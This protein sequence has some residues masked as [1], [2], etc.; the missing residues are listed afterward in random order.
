MTRADWYTQHC[1]GGWRKARKD[2]RC[3]KRDQ[4]GLR[5]HGIILAGS[6]YFGTNA[7]NPHSKNPHARLRLCGAC[8]CEA[9]K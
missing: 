2:N 1:G 7:A 8:A 3:D 4:H 5:C 6:H 9:L